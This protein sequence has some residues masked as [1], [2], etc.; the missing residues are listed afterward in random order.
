[1]SR[2][3]SR[4]SD[5]DTTTSTEV[6]VRSSDMRTPVK[7]I[8]G[9]LDFDSNTYVNVPNKAKST[10]LS[11]LVKSNN[12]NINFKRQGFRYNEILK[13]I[14]TYIYI[15]GGRIIYEALAENLVLPS[16]TTH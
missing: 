3:C 14:A 5:L 11:L 7:L 9:N 8:N 2:V 6:T 13:L 15:V 4:T 12:Y 10:F 1:M 16:I